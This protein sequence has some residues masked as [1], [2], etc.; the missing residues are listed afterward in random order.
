MTSS[1]LPAPRVSAWRAALDSHGALE[2]LGFPAIYGGDATLCEER[3]QRLA[4]ALAHYQSAFGDEPVRAFRAPGRINLRG[5]HVDTHGGWLNLMTHQREVLVVAG[6]SSDGNTHVANTNP[7]FGPLAIRPGD[8]PAPAAGATWSDFMT[9]AK[10]QSRVA[11][12]SGHWRNYLEG[13][14]LR[15]RYA[16]PEIDIGGL[17]IVVDSNLPQGAAL[18]S[19]A[20]LCI[21]LLHAWLGWHG[22]ALDNDALILA[23]QDAE[24]YT[25]SRCGTCDQ[26]AIILGQPNAIVHAALYP[27]RF[28][29]AGA[30]AIALPD[31]LRVLVI[32]SYTRRSISG[33]EKVAYTL[34]RFAYS[35]AMEIFQHALRASGYPE[36]V[37]GH[38]DRLSRITAETLGGN[39]AFY[40]VLRQVPEAL[41]LDALDRYDLP[42]LDREYARYFGD[43]PPALQPKAIGLRGPLLFGI[44]ESERARHFAAA[45]EAGDY[46]RAGDLMTIG[47][48]GDRRIGRDGN[49]VHQPSGDAYL[50]QLAARDTP[51][52]QCPGAYG[53]SSPALDT[54]VDAA[55]EH[56]ALGA[57]L[58]GAGI[59]GTVLALCR[60]EVA[61]DV[62]GGVR[63]VMAGHDYCRVAGLAADLAPGQLT[64]AVVEN[65]ACTGAGEIGG[66]PRG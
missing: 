25:G 8:L 65:R 54:L 45:L 48:D 14:W 12:A 10:V 43:V 40:G 39:R 62:A 27:K 7:A 33:A 6:R 56:G 36:D 9:S 19:S 2:R 37:V 46:T 49:N 41:P 30:R 63:A 26:A 58:T 60:A 17:H 16:V 5:M 66:T 50:D 47:H 4:G 64:E 61:E 44:A 22:A 31:A 53:A 42:D 15:A 55:L 28:T 51:I 3:R 23:A 59:A 21:A 57:S 13:A 29:T 34:N 24:W 11:A 1:T 32:N 35:M 52:E 20:A 38:C 18:S